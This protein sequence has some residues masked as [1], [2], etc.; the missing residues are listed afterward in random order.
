MTLELGGKSAAIVCDD[1]DLE[2]TVSGLVPA[3]MLINGQACAAQ[4]R[5][6]APR[7]HYGEIVDA[8]GRRGLPLEGRRS[9]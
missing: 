1:A 6:L 3:G 9:V 8:L 2:T 4:T 7:S 5:I